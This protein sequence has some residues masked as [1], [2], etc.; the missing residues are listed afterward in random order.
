[1]KKSLVFWQTT[2]FIFTSIAGTLL[3]FLYDWSGQ[4]FIVGLFS[5]VNESTWEHMKLLYFPML[6]FAL[7]ESRYVKNEYENFWCAKLIGN[8]TGLVLIPVIYYTYTGIFGVSADWFNIAIFFISAFV[9][10]WLETRLL[11][12]D[13]K[14]CISNIACLLMLLSIGVIFVSLTIAP[15]NIPLFWEPR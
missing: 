5:A 14:F 11:K 7:I 4:S 12:S 1:M 10:Y 3:H 2:G 15:L 13:K 9:A 8:I 6:A